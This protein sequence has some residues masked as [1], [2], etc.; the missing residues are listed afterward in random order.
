VLVGAAATLA[1]AERTILAIGAHAGDMEVSAGAVLARHARLG[2]RVVLLHL[3]LGEGGNPK[4][5]AAEYG[6]QKRREAVAAAKLLGAEVRFGPYADARIPRGDAPARFVADAICTVKPIHIITHWKNSIHRDHSLTYTIVTDAVLLAA[7]NGCASVRGVW[8]AENWEDQE[9]F[10]PYTY[11]DVTQD[12]ELWRK[13]A[14]AYEFIRGGISKFP[15]LEYYESLARIR[16]ALSG[17]RYAVAFDID[18][19]RKRQV[20]KSLP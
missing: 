17:T 16:G 6:E 5:S 12:F 15:Y 8:Y 1:A 7:V 2:D 4:L 11:V 14:T 18:P 10:Q 19:E 20:L 9:G 3:T 13:A